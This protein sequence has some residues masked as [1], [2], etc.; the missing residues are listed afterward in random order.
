MAR[1]S[2]EL[3]RQLIDPINQKAAWFGGAFE[4]GGTLYFVTQRR[5]YHHYSY[6]RVTLHGLESL[7]ANNLK[8]Q[9]TGCVTRDYEQSWRW[10][11]AGGIAVQITQ[12]MER[13][14][15]SRLEYI[16]AVSNWVNADSQEEKIEIA[17]ETR[18]LRRLQSLDPSRYEELVTN[19]QFMA[20]VIDN[21]AQPYFPPVVRE[22]NQGRIYFELHDSN[23]T[24]LDAISRKH[25]GDVFLFRKAGSEFSIGTRKSTLQNDIYELRLASTD[26]R[27]LV[28]KIRPYLIGRNDKIDRIL[29]KDLGL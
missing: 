23:K 11:V 7:S 6:P 21:S 9:F 15:P 8:D 5:D 22:G 13:F 1:K 14:A 10:S 12:S 2:E 4:I 19:L 25:G 17:K 28:T 20:G 27:K 3:G 16:H 29:M 24:L 26:S 18:G